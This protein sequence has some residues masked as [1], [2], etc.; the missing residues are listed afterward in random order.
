MIVTLETAVAG[1]IASNLALV[2]LLA[3]KYVPRP[4]KPATVGSDPAASKT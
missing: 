3:W 1:L 2:G 4:R